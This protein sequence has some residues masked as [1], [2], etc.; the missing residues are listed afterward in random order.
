MKILCIGHAAYDITLPVSNFPI[1]NTKNR[2]SSRIE[3]GGGPA[4]NAAYLLGMWGADV[5]MC[6]VVGNDNYGKHIKTEL[7]SVNVNTK[8]LEINKDYPT[9][10]SFIMANTSNGSR[11]ILTYRNKDIKVKEMKFEELFDCILIDGQEYEA[12]KYA[13]EKYSDAVSI[14][15]ASRDTKEIRDL[16]KMV[17]YVACSKNFLEE[18]SNIEIDYNNDQTLI[19]AFNILEKE[20]N[21]NI[22]VTLEANGCLYK[23]NNEIKIMPSLKVEAVDTTGAGDIFHGALTYALANKYPYEDALRVANITGALS[24]TKLGS[25]NS[26]PE[27]NSIKEYISEFK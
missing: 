3:N 15:D 16:C 21:T 6:G 7:D 20:F 1:E 12:S 10:S 11:T 9:T 2:V 8:Y 13:I 22:I 14:I 27:K 24:V 25:R 5:Y 18:V 17:D 4:N 19:D 23:E 26:M